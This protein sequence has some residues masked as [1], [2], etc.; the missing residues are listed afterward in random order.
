ML[1]KY[2]FFFGHVS[3]CATK[4]NLVWT[5]LKYDLNVT[6]IKMLTHLFPCCCSW[7]VH[8][9]RCVVLACAY[10]FSAWSFMC[11]HF[12]PS[13]PCLVS[14]CAWYHSYTMSS[15]GFMWYCDKRWKLSYMQTWA[16][17]LTSCN[18]GRTFSWS[19]GFYFYS[20]ASSS[21][22]HSEIS[23]VQSPAQYICTLNIPHL[24]I[25]CD[26]VTLCSSFIFKLSTLYHIFYVTFRKPWWISWSCK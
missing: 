2:I 1:L 18:C 24:L 5:V 16:F 17:V 22:V 19:L 21:F 25:A 14:C 15:V 13:V 9:P 11:Y 8:V 23:L 6:F 10:V 3:C 26:C 12:S 20:I 4:Y 7:F